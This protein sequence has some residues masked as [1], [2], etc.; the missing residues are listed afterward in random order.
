MND[1]SDYFNR[2]AYK[3]K[4][5]IGDRVTGKWNKVPFVGTVLNDNLVSEDEGPRTSINLDLPL[6]HK[7]SWH[8]II[9]VKNNQISKF[10]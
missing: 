2:T 3:P 8:T 1:Y 10:K 7:D 6:K 4:Y 5:F 9:F